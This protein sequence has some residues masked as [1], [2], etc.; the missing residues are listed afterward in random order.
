MPAMHRVRFR[1]TTS[2]LDHSKALHASCLDKKKACPV[3]GNGAPCVPPAKYGRETRTT[4]SPLPP[5]TPP[6]TPWP[7]HGRPALLPLGAGTQRN[8]T[9]KKPGLSVPERGPF[10]T[11][12]GGQE[13]PGGL[14]RGEEGLPR[15]AIFAMD[16]S[17]L[18]PSP[19]PSLLPFPGSRTRHFDSNGVIRPGRLRNGVGRVPGRGCTRRTAW[20]ACPG[21]P[22]GRARARSRRPLR[23][24]WHGSGT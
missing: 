3:C 16:A 11:A 15:P 14:A 23:L 5:P 20:G 21:P 10:A 7:V 13:T 4:S 19:P 9:I 22:R 1:V 24:L 17:P 18:S 6:W 8:W 12:W 2:S